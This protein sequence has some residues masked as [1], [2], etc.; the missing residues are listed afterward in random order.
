MHALAYSRTI[1]PV[2]LLFA[3]V[4]AQ[5]CGSDQTFIHKDW[6]QPGTELVTEEGEGVELALDIALIVD[7][8]CSMDNERQALTDGVGAMLE[9][10]A[11]RADVDARVMTRPTVMGD[12]SS[13]WIDVHDPLAASWIDYYITGTGT[14][15]AE[16]GLDSALYSMTND[17]WRA[18]A[19]SLFFFFSD[20]R[21]Q[22]E[23]VT[24]DL[25]QANI[26]AWVIDPWVASVGAAVHEADAQARG[27]DGGG[28]TRGSGYLEIA[29]WTVPLCEPEHWG[30]VID[31]ATERV[32]G[33][34]GAHKL[35]RRPVSPDEVAVD[36]G[37]GW[38]RQGWVYDDLEVVIRFDPPLTPGQAFTVAYVAEL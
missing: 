18:N 19:D 5:A 21:D 7:H 3:A 25:L 36:L 15:D 30:E 13:G 23:L 6:A 20:E 32:L 24:A 16:R 27:C 14:L 1:R 10:L 33:V 26:N 9:D 17:G 29:T 35:S 8:S 4:Y 22:S 2:L 12:V 28:A 38:T 11:T 37:D 31:Y 34:N